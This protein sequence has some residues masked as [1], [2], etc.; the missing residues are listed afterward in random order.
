MQMDLV[1]DVLGASEGANGV[2]PLLPLNVQNCQRE[3]AVQRATERTEKGKA[4]MF[5]SYT[6]IV[7]DKLNPQKVQFSLKLSEFVYFL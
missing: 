7:D 3:A 2:S 4:S 5:L 1:G 6:E